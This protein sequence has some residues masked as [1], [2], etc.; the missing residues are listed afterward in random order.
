[1]II[2][3]K[4]RFKAPILAGTKIHTLR[5]D[6]TDRW[7]PGVKMHMATGVRTADY[8]CFNDKDEC[9]SYQWAVLGYDFEGNFYI[10]IQDDER[11]PVAELYDDFEQELFAKNDG[12]TDLSELIGWFD[13]EI[14]RNPDWYIRK[15]LIHWTEFKY[16]GD[17]WETI[18]NK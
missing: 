7:H 10:E 14:K 4:P 18:S 11:K 15:K 12:F 2:G 13:A 1:M 8:N 9:K 17:W 3:F 5:D 6:T 16:E